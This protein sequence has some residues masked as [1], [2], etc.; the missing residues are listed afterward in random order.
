MISTIKKSKNTFTLAI[1]IWFHH[2]VLSYN[3]RQPRTGQM[4]NHMIFISFFVETNLA[5]Q[6][7]LLNKEEFRFFLIGLNSIFSTLP[8]SEYTSRTVS[9]PRVQ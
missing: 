7:S 8:Q 5:P 2:P 3:K 4:C 9:T 6:R 1:I